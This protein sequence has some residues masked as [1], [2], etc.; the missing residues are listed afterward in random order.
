MNFEFATAQRVR[1]GAGVVREAGSIAAP[2]GRRIFVVTGRSAARAEPLL[3]SLNAAKLSATLFAVSGEP[4]IERVSE[5]ARLAAEQRSDCVIGFGGGSAIDAGKAIAA[6][7]T[8]PGNPLDYLEVI[9]QNKPLLNGPAPFIALPTT[10]GTGAEVTRNS[11][12]TSP[13]HK[14]KVSLRSPLMLPRAALV[15][16]ELTSHLPPALTAATGFDALAQL[17]EPY[18]SKKA[19]P[20]TDALCREG[21]DRVRR[22]LRRAF[23]HGED[24]QARADMCVASLFSG[25]ALANAALGAV[26][27][28]AAPIGAL[29]EAPHGAVCAALLPGVM[30]VNLESLRRTDP[31]SPVLSR[32]GD[33][34]RILTGCAD[35]TA[36]D[37]VAWVSDLF[38]ALEIPSLR[39]YHI[40]EDHFSDLA[41]KAER[42]SSMKGN[43]VALTAGEMRKILERASV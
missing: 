8:N 1:F 20:M 21:L 38:R 29:F 25:M 43:P 24:R 34:A 18:V 39:A 27:G 35:A 36:D 9:G 33:I 16:P 13:E 23:Q 7:L 5:G 28:F 37:G 11:V 26:H 2:F 19:N 31:Q 40:S 17:V 3:E 12:L 41:E 10:A 15:D 4:T 32:Y 14:L 30:A 42:A 22:S 6:L